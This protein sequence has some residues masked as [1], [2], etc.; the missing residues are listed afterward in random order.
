MLFHDVV[1][2]SRFTSWG[3]DA[4]GYRGGP[5]ELAQ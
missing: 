4:Q 5:G 3:H 1:M 2:F